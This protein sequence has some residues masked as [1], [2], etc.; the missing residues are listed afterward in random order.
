MIG[1]LCVAVAVLL[2]GH[3]PRARHGATVDRPTIPH[4]RT[5][6]GDQ[7]ERQ[8]GRRWL[9]MRTGGRWR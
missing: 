2:A 5:Y 8:G 1:V 3:T 4:A 9:I 6:D 7:L